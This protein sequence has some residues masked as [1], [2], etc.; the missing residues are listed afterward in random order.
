[1]LLARQ[2]DERTWEAL[3]R[4]GRKV[5]VGEK[6]LFDR[7]TSREIAAQRESAPHLEAEVIGRGEYGLRTLRFTSPASLL[8]TLEKIGHVPLPPYIRRPDE[9]SDRLRYQT[10]YARE[11]GSVAAP[12]AGL[13]FTKPLL[14]ELAKRGVERVEVTLHVGL[15]TFQPIHTERIEDHRMHPERFEV[16]PSAAERIN[17]ALPERRRIIAVGTTTVRLLE[18]VAAEHKGHMAAGS[19]ETSLFIL[20]GFHFH[21]VSGLLTNFHLPRTTLLML[22]AYEHAVREGYRFYSYGDCMLIL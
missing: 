4:P 16:E 9:N 15:G 7:E 17:R 19:G 5:R 21:V 20:P 11:P 14:R 18:H 13:H 3:V 8:R 6:L 12:T 2:L 10:V 1:V 22:R